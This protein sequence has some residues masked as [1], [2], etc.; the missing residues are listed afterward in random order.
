MTKDKYNSLEELLKEVKATKSFNTNIDFIVHVQDLIGHCT[1]ND[2]YELSK[3]FKETFYWVYD[4]AEGIEATLKFFAAYS[5]FS[6]NLQSQLSEA[7]ADRDKF[8][9][10]YELEKENS[11]NYAKQRNELEDKNKK[12]LSNCCNLESENAALKNEIIQLKA[13]LYDLMTK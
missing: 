8:N 9:K 11:L 6:E 1:E 3:E 10:L 2:L 5:K 12:I 7:E 4:E 13:Q